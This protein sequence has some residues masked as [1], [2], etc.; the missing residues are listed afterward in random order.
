ME[1]VALA[2]I[3]V[4]QIF[5]GLRFAKFCDLFVFDDL[6]KVSHSVPKAVVKKKF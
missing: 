1:L 5:L 3:Y 6:A 2:I 4:A